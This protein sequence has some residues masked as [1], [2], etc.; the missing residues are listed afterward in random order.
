VL[1][2]AFAL[3]LAVIVYQ[4]AV[5]LPRDTGELARLK[6][7]SIAAELS[8]VGGNS[9]GGGSAHKLEVGRDQP[10]MLTLDIAT[11]E[12]FERYACELRDPRGTV[13]WRAPV[14]AD[15]AK[16]TV[17]IFVPA[18]NWANGDYRLVVEGYEKGGGEQPVQIGI[19]PFT[20]ARR[21]GA[22]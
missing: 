17:P 12:R 15:Q 7:P 4:N 16:D 3:A 20:L 2:P 10:V 22:V 19:Y 18:G 21:P 11:E 1:S 14:S 5:V 6:N 9:R 13:V 8:F